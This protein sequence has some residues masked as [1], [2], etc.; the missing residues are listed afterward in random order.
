[1]RRNMENTHGFAQATHQEVMEVKATIARIETSLQLVCE[2]VQK[3]TFNS[4]MS[5]CDISEFFPVESNEQLDK[6]MDRDNSEWSSRKLEFYNLLYTLSTNNKRGFA[7]GMIKALFS[8]QYI[9]KMKWP[10]TGYK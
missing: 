4:V 9:N 1:M 8:R 10:S 5:G 7:R 2:Q 3:A 6:F